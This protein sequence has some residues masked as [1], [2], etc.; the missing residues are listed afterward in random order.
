M[1][2]DSEAEDVDKVL[3]IAMVSYEVVR[4]HLPSFSA[5]RNNS[6]EDLGNVSP[7]C[8]LSSE[9]IVSLT[10]WIVDASQICRAG[11]NVDR[12]V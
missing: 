2:K 12:V 1:A 8:P 6:Y 5:S 9:E 7:S 11:R 3:G 4:D 10:H